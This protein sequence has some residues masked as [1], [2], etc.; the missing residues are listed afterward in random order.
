MQNPNTPYKNISIHTF[1][2]EGDPEK[3][4]RIPDNKIS[5]HTFF[6]EG[7]RTPMCSSGC[8]GIISIHTF[9][10]EGDGHERRW[11]G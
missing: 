4:K 5:I 11:L 1:F 2:A 7:D 9:F 8:I 6:A 10:A 3:A